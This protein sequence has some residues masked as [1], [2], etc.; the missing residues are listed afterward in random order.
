MNNLQINKENNQN[1]INTMF[2]AK[3]KP[4]KPIMLHLNLSKFKIHK[5]EKTQPHDVKR[6]PFWHFESERRRPL[7]KNYYSK[8]LCKNRSDCQNVNC[9]YS[10]NFIEQI[11]HPDNYKK[12]YINLNF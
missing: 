1:A 2:Q 6:C 12:V 3:N 10:H 11:Y 5:C 7:E 8:I 9:E 4:S